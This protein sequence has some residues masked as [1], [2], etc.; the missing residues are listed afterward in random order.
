MLL[1]DRTLPR[2]RPTT[3]SIRRPRLRL[4]PGWPLWG[5]LVLY[6][7]WWALGLGAFE[8]ILFAIPMSWMLLKHR[9]IKLP[10]GI[11]IWVAFLIWNVVS[12]VMLPAHAPGTLDGSLSGRAL[13]LALRMIQL[14]TA[15]VFLLYI[16][17]LTKEEL[18]PRRIL[19]W[20]SVLF[21]VTVAGGLLALA[22]PHFE[23]TSPMELLLPHHIATNT[24]VNTLVHPAAA[25]VQDVL[26][27]EAPRPA[28]PWG[29]TN[30]WGNNLSLLLI[31]FC[32]YMWEPKVLR[33]HVRLA[34]VLLVAL[35]PVVYSLNRGLWFGVIASIAFII[36]RLARRGDVRATLITVSAIAVGA[37]LFLATPLNHV[38]EQRA[39]HGRS[40]SIRAFV[41]DA[42]F[43]GAVDSPLIGWGDSRK[44]IGSSQSIAV[45]PSE[46]CPLCGGVNVGSAGEIWLVMFSQ[47]L[48]GAAMYAGFFAVAWWRL[49]FDTS[50]IGAGARLITI[51]TVF[52]TFFYNNLPTGLMI[53]MLSIGIASRNLLPPAPTPAE[54]A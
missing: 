25:Q 17:N 34:L 38:V 7:L 48:L 33:S 23:F 45:G 35:I 1:A 16:V 10:P 41:D 21:L 42:S 32:V 53:S 49:R 11:W 37:I 24:Y 20:M 31:W 12:L 46:A 13:S 26:G 39:S 6:P 28:A 22:K 27:F 3:T 14:A 44:V 5:A 47:G 2:A 30:L 54:P 51:L 4:G 15:T 18:P 9:P 19:K 8:F 36:L 52:Y 50:L 43:R 29:Y 40:N